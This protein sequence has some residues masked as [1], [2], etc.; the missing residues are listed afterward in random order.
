VHWGGLLRDPAGRL[1][2]SAARIAFAA[3]LS[4]PEAP[5]NPMLIQDACS[6]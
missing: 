1:D 4:G 2:V 6:T 5:L 3:I